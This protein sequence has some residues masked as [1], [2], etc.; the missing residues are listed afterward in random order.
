M[1]RKRGEKSRVFHPDLTGR[2]VKVASCY[3]C[4][5]QK[6]CSH[7]LE[8]TLYRFIVISFVLLGW[9]FWAYSGGNDFEG[10][11]KARMMAEASVNTDAQ[12]PSQTAPQ[13]TPQTTSLTT[14]HIS[15]DTQ[16]APSDRPRISLASVPTTR[17]I[18]DPTPTPAADRLDIIAA[19]TPAKDA[20]FTLA[21]LTE[22]PPDIREVSGRRVNM[23]TGPGTGYPVVGTLSR[24][25]AV[26]VLRDPGSG[27]VKLRD[28]DGGLVGWM[29]ARML[30]TI[31]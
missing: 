30:R 6:Y 20:V 25:Q 2:C 10:A 7:H 15:S 26:D 16:A 21:T 13:I 23:R 18:S 28:Q 14:M 24:G 5:C 8:G 19:P 22:T 3:C 27:W 1:K 29:S 11:K 12:I 31:N 4:F 9:L 17:L